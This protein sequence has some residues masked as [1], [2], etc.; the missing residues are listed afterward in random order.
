MR[1]G[2]RPRGQQVLEEDVAGLPQLLQRVLVEVQ[3]GHKELDGT[4][5]R[6]LR[7]E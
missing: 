7:G 3:L 6:E 5:L 2:L 4:G 1:R